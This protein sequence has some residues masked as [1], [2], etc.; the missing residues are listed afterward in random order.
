MVLSH[1]FQFRFRMALVCY[2]LN[3]LLISSSR[4]LL[5]VSASTPNTYLCNS[6]YSKHLGGD[7]NSACRSENKTL[8]GSL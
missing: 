5:S 1:R 8:T 3:G 6:I 4:I 7:T 2:L